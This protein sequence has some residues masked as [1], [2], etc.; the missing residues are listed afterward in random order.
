[1]QVFLEK[2]LGL[3]S[4]TKDLLLIL[5]LGA[6]EAGLELLTRDGRSYRLIATGS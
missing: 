4:Q 6:E 5:L 1:L 2:S 3:P